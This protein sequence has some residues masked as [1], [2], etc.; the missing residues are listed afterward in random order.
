MS[1]KMRSEPEGQQPVERSSQR[2]PVVDVLRRC[3]LRN[4]PGLDDVLLVKALEK[5]HGCS[6]CG[7][8]EGGGLDLRL[9]G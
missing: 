6:C 8:A 5:G 3:R 4:G 7:R 9:W 2:Q 1:S